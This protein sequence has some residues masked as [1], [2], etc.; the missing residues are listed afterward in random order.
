[1]QLYRAFNTNES[2]EQI[3]KV[4]AL[5]EKSEIKALVLD[6]EQWYEI[7]DIQNLDIAES[8]FRYQLNINFRD[9]RAGTGGIGV[10]HT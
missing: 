5:F 9:S 4:I 2:Y 10:T 1:M 7:D 3:L 6:G 8:F